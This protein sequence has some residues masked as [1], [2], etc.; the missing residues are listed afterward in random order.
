MDGTV[1]TIQG[2][3]SVS[4]RRRLNRVIH[5]MPELLALLA[6]I[7]VIWG[8]VSFT[9]WQAYAA[10]V[11]SAQQQTS[12]LAR[13]FAESSARI[14]TV[15]DRELLAMRASFAEKGSAFN[16][17]EWVRTQSS[18]DHMTLQ[19]S[20]TDRVGELM[21]LSIPMRGPAVNLSDREHFRVHLDPNEDSLFI[22]KPV[23]GRYSKQCSVQYTRKIFDSAGK[24]AGV[25]VDSRGT[26]VSGQPFR[27]L[28]RTRNLPS[29]SMG[30][31]CGKT[32]GSPHKQ[33]DGRVEHSSWNHC[34]TVASRHAHSESCAVS[35]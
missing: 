30:V 17:M 31:P 16:L 4:G 23:I 25:G 12:T 7:L 11:E 20:F 32:Y 28:E 9:L 6:C 24:F 34:K 27:V 13:A 35:T 14:S 10:A 3:A 5:L 22:S 21:Q 8:A 18:P 26:K 15:L 29:S 19:M 33:R 1:G 2:V